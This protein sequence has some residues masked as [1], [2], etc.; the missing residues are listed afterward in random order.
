MPQNFVAQLR[1]RRSQIQEEMRIRLD[2]LDRLI[3]M[4]ADS[5][6]PDP[7]PAQNGNR[8]RRVKVVAIGDIIER[9][10]LQGLL[11]AESLTAKQ[12]SALIPGQKLG[13]LV[14]AWSRRAESAGIVLG[15][16]LKRS[17]TPAGEKA[18]ALTSDGRRIFGGAVQSEQGAS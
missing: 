8:R 3:A 12:M 9:P 14:S 5:E 16:I 7:N 17:M 4:A 2:E 1:T 11:N 6:L 10:I 18:Y 15:E 13:P